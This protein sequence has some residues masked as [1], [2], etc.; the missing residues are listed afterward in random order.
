MELSFILYRSKA[1][2]TLGHSSVADIVASSTRFNAREGLT[3]FLH[4]DRGYFLQYLEGPKGPL[5]RTVARIYKDRRHGEMVI[6]ADG[7]IDERFFEGWDMGQI[8]AN[9]LPAQGP[10]ATSS[11]LLPA[12]NVDPLPLI[13]AFAAFSGAHGG[14]EIQEISAF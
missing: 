1:R 8:D 4:F 2:K 10:L 9:L 14:M 12:E 7:T 6:L 5:S 11:W 3:G 13:E